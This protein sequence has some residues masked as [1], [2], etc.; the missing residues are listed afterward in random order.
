[1]KK[2]LWNDKPYH[3]L[4]YELKSRYGEKI[5]NQLLIRCMSKAKFSTVNLG[6]YATGKKYYGMHTSP[7]RRATDFINQCIISDYLMYGAEYAN[8]M[9]EDGLVIL[10]NNFTKKELAADKLEQRILKNEKAK[11]LKNY[12]GQEFEGIISSVTEFGIYVEIDEMF[13]GLINISSLGKKMKFIPEIFSYMNKDTKK[14][15]SLGDMVV[16]KIKDV[17]NDYQVDFELVGELYDKKDEKGKIKKK[18]M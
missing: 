6:H 7:I 3:T 5:Y 4:D 1:M 18:I 10:A 9:W 11:Y 2:F 13:E 16:I 17:N 12:I 14:M 8:D 15:Y